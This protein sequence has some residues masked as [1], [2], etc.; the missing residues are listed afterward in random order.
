MGL[1]GICPRALHQPTLHLALNTWQS[2][3]AFSRRCSRPGAIWAVERR[4]VEVEVDEEV[5][6]EVDEPL[7]ASMASAASAVWLPCETAWKEARRRV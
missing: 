3:E 4:L 2:W 7:A 6:E 1:D 5:E